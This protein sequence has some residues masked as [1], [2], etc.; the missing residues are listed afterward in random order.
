MPVLKEERSNAAEDCA[1]TVARVPEG[2]R[3]LIVDDD[4]N[5]AQLEAALGRV[6]IESKTVKSMTEA[7]ECARSGCFQAVLCKPLLSD[8]SWRR[9]VDIANHYDLGFEVVLVTRYCDLT[10][11]AK[12]LNEGAFDV[13]DSLLNRS[14]AAEVATRALWAAYL[15]GAGP[16]TSATSSQNAQGH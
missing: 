4:P 13:L 7:C 14:R 15:K 12:T 9:L 3:L 2:S 5:T 10:A 1:R 11:W 16:N 8:G 6:G